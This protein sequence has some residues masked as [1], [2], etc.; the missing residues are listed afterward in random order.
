MTDISAL[1]LAPEYRDDAI[2][3]FV[4]ARTSKPKKRLKVAEEAGR[5]L[6]WV[7][8]VSEE[9]TAERLRR[10]FRVEAAVAAGVDDETPSDEREAFYRRLDR[11]MARGSAMAHESAGVSPDMAAVDYTRVEKYRLDH[12]ERELGRQ[13]AKSILRGDDAE[14]ESTYVNIEAVL[15]GEMKPPTPDA[16]GVRADGQRMLYR[17]TINGLVGESESAKTIIATCMV[18]EEIRGGGSAL[19][20][21]IDHNGARATL[22]RLIAAGVAAEVLRDPSRFRLAIPSGRAGVLAA[23]AD[24]GSWRPT[25]AVVDSV[26]EVLPMF[27]GDSNSADDYSRVHREV[28]APLAAAGAAVLVIDHL[29]KTA[30]TTGYASGT[31]AKKRAMDGAYYGV[32]LVET[33]R[34]GVGGASALS[35]LKDRHGGVRATTP[36]DT[37]A[38]FRLD[39][40]HDQW[41]WEFHPGRSDEDRA[42]EQADADVAFVLALDPFPTGRAVLQAAVKAKN[43]KGWG[44]DRAHAALT[45]ARARQGVA[46]FPLTSTLLDD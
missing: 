9:D 10:S 3:L 29:A 2:D 34:P 39:S 12:L 31:G 36:S 22:A 38:V 41:T 24:A 30:L 5:L 21:E 15:D 33:Y 7:S 35:I 11:G 46:T 40:R 28:F 44:N 32:K 25:I 1:A 6:G 18:A 17:G 37:A 43:G 13:Q 4:A 14:P 19:W 42:D 26:G 8:V 16:G 27:D 45:A 20:L 23:V